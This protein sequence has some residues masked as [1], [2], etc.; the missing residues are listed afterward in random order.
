MQI[1]RPKAPTRGTKPCP[2]RMEIGRPPKLRRAHCP[3]LLKAFPA[4]DRASLRRPER[5]RGFFSALRAAGF[6]FGAN[7]GR[8]AS[9]AATGL[10]AFCFTTF[11]ALGF[12]L[13]SFVGKEHL[14]AGGKNEFGATLRALQYFVVVFHGS[15]P[16]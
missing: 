5:N 6:G 11:A 8:S 14:F 12:V 10:R 3:P 1:K 13:E 16:P 2:R 7:R 9:P 15:V 4:E